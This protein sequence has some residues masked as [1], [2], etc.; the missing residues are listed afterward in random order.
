MNDKVGN[1]SFDMPQPGEM[2]MEKPYSEQ[3]AQVIDSEVRALIQ[4]AH[5]HTTTLL[6][7]HKENVKKVFIT[8]HISSLQDISL[9]I[10]SSKFLNSLI[11]KLN[12]LHHSSEEPF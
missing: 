7:Q 8:L 3:T 4:R 12:P 1:V 5:S 11:K 6:S 10:C 9:F 2:V